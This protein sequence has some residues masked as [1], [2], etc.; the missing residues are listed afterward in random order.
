MDK[1]KAL[2]R[3]SKMKTIIHVL[4]DGSTWERL[5]RYLCELK[6]YVNDTAPAPKQEQYEYGSGARGYRD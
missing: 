1:Q 4:I 5:N 2:K 6:E 3:I